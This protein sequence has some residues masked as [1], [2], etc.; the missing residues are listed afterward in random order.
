MAKT[1]LALAVTVALV[2]CASPFWQG[3]GGKG[4]AMLASGLRQYEEGNYAESARMLQGAL[5]QGLRDS[6][7]VTAYKHL[8]FV[9]CAEGR[10]RQCREHFIRALTLDPRME[11]A[12][13]EAGHP[14][15]GP[16]YRAVKSGR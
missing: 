4:D 8:A 5:D 2:G 3:L 9:N 12:P 16:V 14:V 11:L 6:D 10:E 1:F 15:W 7:R 13:A